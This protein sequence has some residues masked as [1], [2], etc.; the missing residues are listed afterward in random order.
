MSEMMTAMMTAMLFYHVI[1]S[2]MELKGVKYKIAKLEATISSKPFKEKS[3]KM[4]SIPK[5][6]MMMVMMLIFLAVP[7][8]AMKTAGLEIMTMVKISVVLILVIEIINYIGYNDF[9][10]KF[11]EL[12]S[13]IKK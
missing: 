6:I 8:F 13:R 10:K 1:H 7:M 12:N 11:G 5:M 2:I 9:H 3:F 4:D